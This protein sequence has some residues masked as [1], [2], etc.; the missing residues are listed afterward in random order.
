[1]RTKN[2]LIIAGFFL[3]AKNELGQFFIQNVIP[4]SYS[5]YSGIIKD[6]KRAL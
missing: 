2:F 5:L 1:M 6:V 3:E 4:P